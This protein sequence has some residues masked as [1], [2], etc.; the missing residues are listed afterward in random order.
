VA[1]LFIYDALDREFENNSGLKR[2]ELLAEM[3]GMPVI[4]GAANIFKM[5]LTAS[6]DLE[7]TTLCT[8]VSERTQGHLQQKEWRKAT[9]CA[10]KLLQLKP[11]GHPSVDQQLQLSRLRFERHF[12]QLASE[13]RDAISDE[14][15]DEAEQM[16]QVSSCSK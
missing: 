6:D 12:G 16:I 5:V 7:L 1:R 9:E 8:A 4:T 2:G 14:R 11:I 3:K 13:C 15:F 10:K